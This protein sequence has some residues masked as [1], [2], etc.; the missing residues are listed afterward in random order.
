M[1]A[2]AYHWDLWGAAYLINGGCSDDGF[3]YFRRWLVL[4]GRDVF[5]AAVSNPDTLAE[6]A[7]GLDKLWLVQVSE[8]GGGLAFLGREFDVATRRLGPLQ[9]RA[10]PVLRDAPPAP[11]VPHSPALPKKASEVT[12]F[13][14]G[15]WK[16]ETEVLVPKLSPE[17]A[18]STG[19][20]TS[21]LIAG[22]KFLRGHGSY[23]DGFIPGYIYAMVQTRPSL[24][25][26]RPV[27]IDDRNDGGSQ[28]ESGKEAT[29]VR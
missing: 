14:V 16:S 21:E 19:I 17:A 25:P 18:R 15:S 1:L 6:V 29:N 9:H 12:A 23:R 11:P 27:S 22:G 3:E 24:I 20:T 26:H 4:Q 8:D 28:E 2:E 7:E 10:A 13:L 5:Q